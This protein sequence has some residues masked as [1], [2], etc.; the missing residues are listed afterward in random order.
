MQAR[1]IMTANPE[2]VTPS[3]GVIRAASLMQLLDVGFMPVVEDRNSMRLVGVITDRDLATRHVAPGHAEDCPVEKH[4]TGDRLEVVHPDTDVHDV[5]GRMA[6]HKLRRLAVVDREHRLLGV[7]AQ[8]DVARH[9]GAEETRRVERMLEEISE[10][11][12]VP[13]PA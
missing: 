12:P 7:I 6:R 2:F 3:D 11:A 1:E 5:I 10:P 13:V 4:M 8:A 9:V